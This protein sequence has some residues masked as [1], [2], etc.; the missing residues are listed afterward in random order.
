MSFLPATRFA[1]KLSPERSIPMMSSIAFY[2][3]SRPRS[4][5]LNTTF[6]HWMEKAWL[7]FRRIWYQVV[8][9]MGVLV[10]IGKSDRQK[11][12]KEIMA[13]SCTRNS[14]QLPARASLL[15]H[16]LPITRFH[17]PTSMKMMLQMALSSLWSAMQRPAP[18][19]APAPTPSAQPNLTPK[20]RPSSSPSSPAKR[21]T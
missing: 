16:R 17:T 5:L 3:L 1:K 11:W 12:A 13:P 8:Q 15:S 14:H 20:P 7:K 19:L 18:Q 6:L 2:L 10:G 4:F 9:Q 21:N